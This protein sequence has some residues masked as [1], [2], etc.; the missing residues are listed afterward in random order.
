MNQELIAQIEELGLSNKEARVYVANLMLGPASVQQIA[1]FAE[2]KRVTTYVI[3]ESLI[4][5]GLVSQTMKGKKTLFG[6]E[7][8]SNL[9]RLLEKREQELREQ[10]TSFE[11]VL[12]EL[13]SLKTLPEDAPGVK[14]YEGSDGI[15]TLFA[16][17]YETPEYQADQIFGITNVDQLHEFFPDFEREG[18]NPERV[19]NRIKSKIVY[20]S[21]KG[22]VYQSG[23]SSKLRESRFVPPEKYPL[24][25]DFT[26]VGD[27]VFLLS[28]SGKKPIGISIHSREIAKGLKV[29]FDLA[30]AQAG[31]YKDR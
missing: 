4:S 26:V 27:Y 19:K 29:V 1:D 3:L 20:T 14:F 12:P 28:L 23:D 30:W 8:P 2:I 18:G 11:Q 17:L 13:Q 7:D 24:N 10:K 5:L 21:S 25:G 16:T 6:A 31:E 9:R 15:K 22:P